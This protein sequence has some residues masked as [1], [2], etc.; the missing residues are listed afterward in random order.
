M[1]AQAK[2]SPAAMPKPMG[3]LRAAQGGQQG[4][5]LQ[6]LNQLPNPISV[7]ISVWQPMAAHHS[8]HRTYSQK[9]LV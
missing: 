1:T 8:V 4:M 6:A 7:V 9:W 2:A 5:Q 3:R